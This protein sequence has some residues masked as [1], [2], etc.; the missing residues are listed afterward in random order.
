M[1]SIAHLA[2]DIGPC[3]PLR[4]SANGWP[5]LQYLAKI[6][7]A[8]AGRVDCFWAAFPQCA[9]AGLGMGIIGG[10]LFILS[11]E[12]GHPSG[13]LADKTNPQTLLDATC[14]HWAVSGTP[15]AARRGGSIESRSGTCGPVDVT[16]TRPK[17]AQLLLRQAATTK[18]A[19]WPTALGPREY[20]DTIS[21]APRRRAWG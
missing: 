17:Q 4:P 15:S 7:V 1:G 12:R 2:D 9:L 14:L 19:A 18:P 13:R 6:P 21:P 20:T 16:P 8:N 3:S 11:D 5:L 10:G